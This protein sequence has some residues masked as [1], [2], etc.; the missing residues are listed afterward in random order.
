MNKQR[1]RYGQG[2]RWLMMTFGIIMLL[3]SPC[4]AHHH[5]GA[6][7][8]QVVERCERDQAT[9]DRH[10]AHH[11][12][13]QDEAGCVKKQGAVVAG[14]AHVKGA[15]V[16]LLPPGFVAAA[17]ALPDPCAADLLEAEQ[18]TSVAARVSAFV[19]A[20]GRRGPPEVV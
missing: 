12:A 2:L 10:T 20:D 19:D 15:A 1:Q 18:G 16:H 8:C 9:N 5:H 13:P 4:V 3:V 17:I 7:L 6:R 11:E 14:K